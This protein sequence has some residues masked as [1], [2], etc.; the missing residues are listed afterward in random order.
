[1]VVIETDRLLLRQLKEEDIPGLHLIF[2]DPETMRYYPSPFS[3][4]KTQNWVKRNQERYKKDGYGLWAVCLKGNNELIGDC[5]L[6]KQKIDDNTEIEIGYHI[7]KKYW[8]NGF[9]SE[10]AMACKEYGFNKLG[11]KK[12]ISIIDPINVPSIRVAE[13]NGFIK[14]KEVFIFNKN[15]SI[16]S[17][18]K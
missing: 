17:C 13:K 11:L 10:A 1:M 7:N 14:E 6:V 8:C 4:E 16:Y 15:H 12:L 3:Y 18:F 9:G 2:S 5:G